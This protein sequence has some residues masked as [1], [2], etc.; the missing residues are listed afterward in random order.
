MR[1]FDPDSFDFDDQINREIWEQSAMRQHAIQQPADVSAPGTFGAQQ[2][3]LTAGIVQGVDPNTVLPWV[4]DLVGK[5][6]SSEKAFFVVGSAYAGFIKQYSGRRAT[7]NLCRYATAVT[8]RLFQERFLNDVVEPDPDY[9]GKLAILFGHAPAAPL[10]RF[11]ARQICVLDLCR[12]SFV[13]RGLRNGQRKNWDKPGDG[14]VKDSAAGPQPHIFQHYVDQNSDWTWK[15]FMQSKASKIVALGTIAEHGVL[16]LFHEHGFTIRDQMHPNPI[17][18][19]EFAP[20]T[21][22]WV[23]QYADRPLGYWLQ[24]STWWSIIPP[25]PSQRTFHLLPVYHPRKAYAYDPNYQRTRML[26][27]GFLAA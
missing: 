7:M 21:A 4:P 24:H 14:I 5:E 11:S 26:L 15:R 1:F 23:S 19:P 27:P 13:R 9:Y 6:W 8:A 12:A 17:D 10:P 3:M 16:R 18:L 20:H 22:G 2:A 25:H